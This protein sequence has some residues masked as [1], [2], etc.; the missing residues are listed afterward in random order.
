MF[1]TQHSPCPYTTH[2]CYS[3]TT[4]LPA[5]NTDAKFS[6]TLKTYDSRQYYKAKMIECNFPL[7]ADDILSSSLDWSYDCDHLA[8]SL[9][10]LVSSL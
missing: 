1:C 7:Y 5:V 2:K 3:T 8:A 4:K 9:L 6:P 10:V